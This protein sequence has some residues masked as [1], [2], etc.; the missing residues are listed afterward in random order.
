MKK[1]IIPSILCLLILNSCFLFEYN[2]EATVIVKNVGQLGI[3]ADM[4]GT[5]AT[6]A[7]GEE[8]EFTLT[9]PGKD[10]MH[11]NLYAHVTHFEWVN[12]YKNFWISNGETK[13]VEFSFYMDDLED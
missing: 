11:I 9:W 7:P 12:E 8:E 1:I 10:D 4:E 13:T 3:I 5:K 2:G 6:I